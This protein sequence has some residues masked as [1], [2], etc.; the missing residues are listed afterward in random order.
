MTLSLVVV[1]LVLPLV[2]WLAWYRSERV[3]YK[4]PARLLPLDQTIPRV[5]SEYAFVVAVLTDGRQIL[6]ELKTSRART[7]P[8]EGHEVELLVKG[9]WLQRPFVET[10]QWSPESRPERADQTFDGLLLAAYYL[11][12]G[13]WLLTGPHLACAAAAFILSGFLTGGVTRSDVDY[14]RLPLVTRL[15]MGLWLLL[16]GFLT[17]V[18]F[19]EPGVLVLFPGVLLAF[20]FGQL[21]GMFALYGGQKERSAR[22]QDAKRE[23]R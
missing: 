8:A 5:R 16:S 19:R 13:V 15:F 18:L 1:A 20:S 4:G 17:V 9:R 10:V 12:A 22:A 2:G 7:I 23:D 21:A 11:V 3:L 6:V 14:T